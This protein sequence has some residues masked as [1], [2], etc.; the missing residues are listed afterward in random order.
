M[1]VVKDWR[2]R[3]ILIGSVVVYPSRTGSSLWMS[4]GTVES[5]ETVKDWR[6]NDVHKIGVRRTDTSGYGDKTSSRVAYPEPKRL[7]VVA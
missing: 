5:I 4:E 1:A 3:V 6:G 7:T 2:D